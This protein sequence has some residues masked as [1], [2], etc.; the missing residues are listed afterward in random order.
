MKLYNYIF[1]LLFTFCNANPVNLEVK[2]RA[3][4]VFAEYRNNPAQYSRLINYLDIQY[5][6]SNDVFYII[7]STQ[8]QIYHYSLN[9]ESSKILKAYNRILKVKNIDKYTFD[10][11]FI[12]LGVIDMYI[13]ER[14]YKKAEELLNASLSRLNN[15]YTNSQ[16]TNKL[17]EDI[18]YIKTRIYYSYAKLYAVQKKYSKEKNNMLHTLY[19]INLSNSKTKENNII[20]QLLFETS[21][22]YINN[23]NIDSAEYYFNKAK[24]SIIIHDKTIKLDSLHTLSSLYCIKKEY[25]R[26]IENLDILY[27]NLNKTS[28]LALKLHVLD[29]Y[30]ESYKSLN[31]E[32]KY[33]YYLTLY[34]DIEKQIEEKH[35]PELVSQLL[36]DENL[37]QKDSSTKK[38]ITII[39]FISLV[40]L[41]SV[42]IYFFFVRKKYKKDKEN[43]NSEI[44]KVKE[45]ASKEL[46][47]LAYGDNSIAFYNRFKEIYPNLIPNLEKQYPQLTEQDKIFCTYLYLGFSTKEIASIENISIRTVDSR[48]YRLRKKCLLD[49]NEDL[50]EW[51]K[52]LIG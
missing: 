50:Y 29:L 46:V 23:N 19:Y 47:D 21:N 43:I 17:K 31:N 20:S 14:Y 52:N 7:S 48:K 4:S 3:D 11:I 16:E 9:N 8:L 13:K 38:I 10:L 45:N 6:K 37:K 18:N 40:I 1:L 15:K 26:A 44:Q 36:V 24:E 22:S 27:K 25:K 39:I 42:A 41:T 28:S 2:K 12:E 33:L 5:K 51:I 49:S 30:C 34:Q 32:T 35:D